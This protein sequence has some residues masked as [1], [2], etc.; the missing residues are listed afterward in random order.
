MPRRTLNVSEETWLAV[1]ELRL[2][3]MRE[4]RKNFTADQVLL[5]LFAEKLGARPKSLR[6]ILKRTLTILPE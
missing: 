1:Q 6:Q 3:R 5:E 4:L 2:R